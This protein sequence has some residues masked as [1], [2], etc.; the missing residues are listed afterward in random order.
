MNLW[1][2]DIYETASG[3]TGIVRAALYLLDIRHLFLRYPGFMSKYGHSKH[4]ILMMSCIAEKTNVK[5]KYGAN[6]HTQHMQ[7]GLW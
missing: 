3:A 7:V 4:Y 6:T 2:P 1:F 5:A